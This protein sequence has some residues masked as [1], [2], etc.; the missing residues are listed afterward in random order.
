MTSADP[1]TALPNLLTVAET[2]AYLRLSKATVYRLFKTGEVPS[3]KVGDSRRV[4]EP[5][6]ESYVQRLRKNASAA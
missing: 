5:D 6:L 3:I 1:E 4:A 2:C